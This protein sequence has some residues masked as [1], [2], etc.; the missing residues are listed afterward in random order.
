MV[1]LSGAG[2]PVCDNRNPYREQWQGEAKSCFLLLC[3]ILHVIEAENDGK[4][5]FDLLGKP[6]EDPCVVAE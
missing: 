4:S 6:I 1:P 5:M 2:E 3:P